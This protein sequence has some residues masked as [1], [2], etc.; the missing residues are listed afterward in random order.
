M[1]DFAEL[2]DQLPPLA[3]VSGPQRLATGEANSYTSS[4]PPPA[5]VQEPRA[6]SNARRTAEKYE[7]RIAY[8]RRGTPP[9][10]EQRRRAASRLRDYYCQR[11]I[12]RQDIYSYLADTDVPSDHNLWY[13]RFGARLLAV[14]R[15]E[16]ESQQPAK[17]A[18]IVSQACAAG[19]D[20][21]IMNE[22]RQLIEARWRLSFAGTRKPSRLS[23]ETK[24]FQLLLTSLRL[25]GELYDQARQIVLPLLRTPSPDWHAVYPRIATECYQAWL[26]VR[27]GPRPGRAVRLAQAF[28]TIEEQAKAEGLEPD[29]VNAVLRLCARKL[30]A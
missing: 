1:R 28:S 23:P 24:R 30:K 29:A 27:A 2:L 11:N 9:A 15:R 5:A 22:V 19:L 21:K 10:A 20:P 14:L 6:T 8:P 25:R 3:E 7:R 13:F 17:M 4:N 16:Q 12:I 26:N 18:E